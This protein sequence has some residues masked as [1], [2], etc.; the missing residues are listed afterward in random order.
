MPKS[1][2]AWKISPPKRD[3]K[4]LIYVRVKDIKDRYTYKNQLNVV[5]EGY[6]YI[7]YP[8]NFSWKHSKRENV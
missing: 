8:Y 4:D 5:A 2:F 1:L 6:F 3:W 7:W